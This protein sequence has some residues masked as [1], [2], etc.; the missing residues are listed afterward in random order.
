MSL[1]VTL[2]RLLTFK[3]SF[4]A[5]KHLQQAMCSTLTHDYLM[6]PVF[7]QPQILLLQQSTFSDVLS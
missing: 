2:Q 7:A 3:T 4:S 5:R 1:T 6:N